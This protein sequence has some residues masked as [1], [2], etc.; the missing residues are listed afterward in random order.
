M[1]LTYAHVD[2]YDDVWRWAVV[3]GYQGPQEYGAVI[4]IISDEDG[5]P[6]KDDLINPIL[7]SLAKTL[8]CPACD[9]RMPNCVSE[10][11]PLRGC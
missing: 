8:E 2:C 4:A 3:T 7:N 9:E 10:G 6:I 5:E 1:K 11:C